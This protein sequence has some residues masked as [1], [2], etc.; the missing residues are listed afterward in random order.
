[1]SESRRKDGADVLVIPQSIDNSFIETSYVNEDLLAQAREVYSSHP[2]DAAV[3]MRFYNEMSAAQLAYTDNFQNIVAFLEKSLSHFA[4]ATAKVLSIDWDAWSAKNEAAYLSLAEAG[5]TVV[6]WIA[7]PELTEVASKTPFELDEYF[8]EGFMA[9]D[10]QNLDELEKDLLKSTDL[11]KWHSLVDEI[12]ASIR[13]GRHR[14]AIPSTLIIIEGFMAQSLVKVSLTTDKNRSPFKTL[15]GAGWHLEDTFD[16]VYWKSVVVFLRKLF[17]FS[18]FSQKPPEFINR[19]WIL[20]G[21]QPVDWTLADALRLVNA[22][23][24]LLYLFEAVR[25]RKLALTS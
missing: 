10:A 15:E 2:A 22:L 1:M 13:A 11:A 21:R 7:L 5:W 17:A 20:H 14:V 4:E 19:H 9:N 3:A 23:N 6:D 25:K 16:A 8:T 12:F 18:D 24:T